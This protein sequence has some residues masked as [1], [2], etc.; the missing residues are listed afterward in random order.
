MEKG[1]TYGATD[2]QGGNEGTDGT[3]SCGPASLTFS[4]TSFS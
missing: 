4:S 1:T 2:R 3:Y